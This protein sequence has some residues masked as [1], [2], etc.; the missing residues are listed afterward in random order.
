MKNSEIMLKTTNVLRAKSES[1]A[2]HSCP[3]F[4]KSN[5]NDSLSVALF[6]KE[7]RANHSQSLFKKSDFEQKRE[8]QKENSQPQ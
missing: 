6:Y 5:E 3:S 4:V 2:N 1:Q 8:Q 7:M